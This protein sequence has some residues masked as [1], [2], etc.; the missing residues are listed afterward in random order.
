MAYRKG[1]ENVPL[2]EINTKCPIYVMIID[3]KTDEVVQEHKMD[4]ADINDRIWLGRLT[5][6]A[7]QNHHSIETMSLADA[8]APHVEGN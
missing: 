7:V 1:V 8:E 3:L 4:Y 6:W 5:F 2:K